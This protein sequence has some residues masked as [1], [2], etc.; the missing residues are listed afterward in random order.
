MNNINDYYD[1][2]DNQL[3]EGNR[4]RLNVGK[5]ITS[6]NNAMIEYAKSK[7]YKYFL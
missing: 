6:V 4:M 3:K 7:G 5:W 1:K 2:L